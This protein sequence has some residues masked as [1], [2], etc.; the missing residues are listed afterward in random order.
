[1]VAGRTGLFKLLARSLCKRKHAHRC[2]KVLFNK[3]LPVPPTTFERRE[4]NTWQQ[5]ANYLGLSVRA[6]QNYEKTA[7]LPVHRLAGQSRGRVWAY[8]DELDAWKSRALA[9]LEADLASTAPGDDELS[10]RIFQPA[11]PFSHWRYIGLVSGLYALL[12]AEAVILETAYQFDRYGAKALLGAVVVF[13]CVLAAFFS[14]AVVDWWRTAQNK[15]GGL[16]LSITI[17][18]GGAALLQFGLWLVLPTTAITEQISR[19]PWSAQ[20]AYLKNV[21]LYFLP[22]ATFYVLLPFHFVLTLQRELASKRHGPVLALLTG[23]RKATTPGAVYL[24]VG[25]LALALF[26]V[27]LL[28]VVM[29]QD[30]FDHLKPSPYKNLFMHLALG[31]TLLLFGIALLCL[32]WYSRVLNEIKRECLRAAK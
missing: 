16:L 5:I 11:F 14:A 30:L 12:C 2:A 31:R 23:E 6:V 15:S 28:S 27:A 21:A 9:G 29:T 18:Y 3:S 19:Q 24:R 20:S 22:L 8:T 25:W 17:V 4:L 7:G 26:V 13:C 1:V 32:L 10:Q